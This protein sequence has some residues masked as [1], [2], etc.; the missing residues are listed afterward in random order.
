VVLVVLSLGLL[1]T[2]ERPPVETVQTGYRGVGMVQNINPRIL[3]AKLDANQIPAA[4]DPAEPGSGLASEA[5]QNVP[6]LGHLTENE[7]LRIMQAVTEWVSPEQGCAYCHA[8][9]EDFSS[10]NLYTKVVSRRMFQMTQDLNINWTS[11]VGATGVT[12]YTCHRGNPVPANIWFND[13]GRVT[14]AGLLG[15]AAGQNGPAP[16]AGLASLPFDPFT[17]YL[18][19]GGVDHSIRVA[20]ATALP[21]GNRRSIK[22][23][24]WTYSLMIHMSE[25][26]GVNCTYC[27]NSR[28]FR[29]WD[30]STPART[31]AWH[32]IQMVRDVNASYLEP[33]QP[34]FPSHRKG[35]LGDAPKANCTTCHAGVYKPFFGVSMLKDYPE[36]ARA[37]AV[38]APAP[39]Q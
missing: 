27:H 25:S 2:F 16:K 37:A 31:T 1:F 3:E 8:E 38:P 24:E 23:T 22:E 33:L 18:T 34:V 15:N 10:D 32:G 6:V 20:S 36:L 5:Y 14:A 21:S 39:A 26:L 29:D 13:P 7:F 28:S 4:L 11:H 30:Q 35:P 17:P 19:G 9:G 12:C